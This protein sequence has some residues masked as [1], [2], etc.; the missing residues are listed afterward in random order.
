MIHY[1]DIDIDIDN[2]VGH[3]EEAARQLS[4]CLNDEH[5]M[6]KTF[7]RFFYFRKK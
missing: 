5:Y 3:Y 2:K 7:Y 4:I 6:L 1:I